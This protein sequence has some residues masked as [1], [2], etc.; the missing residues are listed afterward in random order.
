[1]ASF[2]GDPTLQRCEDL[3]IEAEK[4]KVLD[5]LRSARVIAVQPPTGRGKTIKLPEYILDLH[6]WE[7]RCKRPVLVVQQSTFAAQL[8]VNGFV[9]HFAY[10]QEALH[11]WTG[12]DKEEWYRAGTTKFT[13]TTYGMLWKLVSCHAFLSR[14]SYTRSWS[15]LFRYGAIFLDEFADLAPQQEETCKVVSRLVRE[16][17]LQDCRRLVVAGYGTRAEYVQKIVGDHAYVRLEK[18]K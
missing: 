8:F 5:G 9:Q 10:A 6:W 7:S 17:V 13:I 16:D 18:R 4:D 11:L 12:S 2:H 14:S 1:M 15:P 3:P